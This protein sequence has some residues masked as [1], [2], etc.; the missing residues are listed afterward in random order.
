MP[1]QKRMQPSWETSSG[2]P[3]GIGGGVYSL[4]A[5]RPKTGRPAPLG[6]PEDPRRRPQEPS[7]SD[8][9]GPGH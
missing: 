2:C 5:S 1:D 4:G 7:F 6:L 9:D 3:G 8:A